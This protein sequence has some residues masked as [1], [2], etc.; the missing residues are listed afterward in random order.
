MSCSKTQHRALDEDGIPDLAIKS[1]TLPTELSVLPLHM[2]LQYIVISATK[3]ETFLDEKCYSFF[4]FT[5]K[6]KLWVLIRT[7]SLRQFK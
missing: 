2:A 3:V 4:Y 7:A 6:Q 1:D 5:L